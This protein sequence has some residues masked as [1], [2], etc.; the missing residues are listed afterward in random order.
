[1]WLDFFNEMEG[2]RVT[3]RELPLQQLLG[4]VNM[5]GPAPS[6]RPTFTEEDFQPVFRT[7]KILTFGALKKE[8]GI[9]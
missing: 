3:G 8:G 2:V 1:M 7:L 6:Y 5:P 9:S 4:G